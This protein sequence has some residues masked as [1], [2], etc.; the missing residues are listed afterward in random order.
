MRASSKRQSFWAKSAGTEK[1][2]RPEFGS[3]QDMSK[4]E[5]L[6]ELM[7]SYL[8]NDK[9]SLQR[10]IVDHVEHTLAKTRFDFKNFHCYEAVSL[11]VRDRLIESFNDTQQVFIH[12]DVKFLYYL[13][14]EFLIGRYLQNAL[15]N[16]DLEENYRQALEDIG[17]HLE[18]IYECETDPALGNGGLGRL[19]ACFLDS[20]ATLNYPAWVMVSDTA[21]VSS[22]S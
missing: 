18:S 20:L 16:L 14:L 4:N 8:P 15:I 7:Q 21:M 22:V 5:K 11:S 2:F 9:D 17:F 10:A 19:A 12:K 13:S 1:G 3:Q 6:W